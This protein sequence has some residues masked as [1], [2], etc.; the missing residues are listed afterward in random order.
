[1]RAVVEACRARHTLLWL[2]VAVTL[3]TFA[4]GLSGWYA[5]DAAVQNAKAEVSRTAD[6][7]AQYARRLLEA[8]AL[9]LDRANDL[10]AGLSDSQIESREH[11]LH[12]A[13]RD[14]ASERQSADQ[15]A[16]YLFVY[17]RNAR[18][19]V[20][21]NIY[22]APAPG[23]ALATREFN[24]ALRPNDRPWAHVSPIYVGRDTGSAFFAVTRRRERTG[25]GLGPDA[26]DGVI[27]ASMF[28]DKINP[29]LLTLAIDPS[30]VIS[31]V[32]TDGRL[33][34]RSGG[35][36]G[37]APE[38][39]RLGAG[40]P[41]TQ[42]MASGQDFAVVAGRSSVDGLK[43]IAAFRRVGTD[44]PVYVSV[45]R[46]WSAV[47]SRWQRCQ[48]CIPTIGPGSKPITAGSP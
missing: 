2:A 45:A 11:D 31:F 16:F 4:L 25:N 13:L 3:P 9:R 40:S 35:F 6:A 28:L 34:A 47:V 23:P 21:S 14:I 7:A 1:M 41:M 37:M 22:P 43:R 29:T 42:V 20:T 26:Y 19:L 18:P 15:E 10:L 36:V 17:D 8:Q 38:T 48:R 12:V 27:N 33:L 39:A 46:T 30:D 24:Q 44:W 5:W 32:R